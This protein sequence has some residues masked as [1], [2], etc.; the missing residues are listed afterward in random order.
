MG[1]HKSI[2]DYKAPP[3]SRRVNGIGEAAGGR[4]RSDGEG[5]AVS[6]NVPKHSKTA[7]FCCLKC[8]LPLSDKHFSDTASD[9]LIALTLEVCRFGERLLLLCLF[10]CLFFSKHSRHRSSDSLTGKKKTW[11]KHPQTRS[12]SITWQRFSG[13][14]GLH[15]NSW[16]PVIY[17]NYIFWPT[18][19]S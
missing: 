7:T 1:R 19:G 17:C 9:L 14:D 16:Q 8:A 13:V 11:P 5:N 3:Q 6:E 12:W 15:G 2:P 10:F 18:E 4:C